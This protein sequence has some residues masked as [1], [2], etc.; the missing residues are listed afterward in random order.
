LTRQLLAFSRQ[1]VLEPKILDLNEVVSDMEKMLRRLIGE[2]IE[3]V[4]N[5]DPM[6]GRARAD[7]GVLLPKNCG[8]FPATLRGVIERSDKAKNAF[9]FRFVLIE[10]ANAIE[11]VQIVQQEPRLV[12][13]YVYREGATMHGV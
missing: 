13:E 1:Q 4:T 6:L 8:D 5:R 2:D 11:A 7:Q 3:L 12:R 10:A 9:K